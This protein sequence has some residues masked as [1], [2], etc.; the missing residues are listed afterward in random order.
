MEIFGVGFSELIFV[1][2]IALLVLGPKDMAKTARM[3]GTWLNRFV[4]S[5]GWK[6]ARQVRD[7]P[8]NLMRDANIEKHLKEASLSGLKPGA[9]PPQRAAAVPRQAVENNQIAPPP[10]NGQVKP[11]KNETESDQ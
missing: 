7:L 9:A 8:R 5:D 10:S 6:M 2:V 3:M 11:E 4:N 1:L